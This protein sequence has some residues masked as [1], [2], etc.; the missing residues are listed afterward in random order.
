MRIR[1]SATALR[2]L[3]TFMRVLNSHLK[4]RPYASRMH[5]PPLLQP[6]SLK[7]TWPSKE[8]APR[9]ITAGEGRARVLL[10]CSDDGD[11]DAAARVRVDAGYR[12]AVHASHQCRNMASRMQMMRR[13]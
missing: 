9:A 10:A 13:R 3:L 8:A 5:V 4:W 7:S 2:M 11:T 6:R 1:P 12:A